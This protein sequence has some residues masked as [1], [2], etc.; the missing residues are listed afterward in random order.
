MKSK[1]FDYFDWYCSETDS[2]IYGWAYGEHN[3]ASNIEDD[4]IKINNWE[5]KLTK[6]RTGF[7]YVWGWPGPDA[8]IYELDDYGKTWAFSKEELIEGLK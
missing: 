8:N 7:I 2:P 3:K 4:I 5:L 1:H 6:D